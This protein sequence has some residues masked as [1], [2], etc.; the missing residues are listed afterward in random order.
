MD[1]L[2]TL[3]NKLKWNR[4][5]LNQDLESNLNHLKQDNLKIQDFI[6]INRNI[7]EL[8]I[9][10]IEH[11]KYFHVLN[12]LM[13]KKEVLDFWLTKKFD[14]IRLLTEFMNDLDNRIIPKEGYKSF[15]KE[16]FNL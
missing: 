10:I 4:T 2:L 5:K 9:P 13:E 16:I 1:N 7:I 3:I 15:G 14:D 12:E 11:E 6:D 8:K